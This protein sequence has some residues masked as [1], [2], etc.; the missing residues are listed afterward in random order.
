MSW[1]LFSFKPPSFQALPDTLIA[2]ERVILRP[3]KLD[4][5]PQWADIRGRNK[6]R[7]QPYE[8]T[9]AKNSLEK[10]FFK[11]RLMRQYMEWKTDHARPFL[12]FKAEDHALIGGININNICRGAAQYASLGYWIDADHEEQGY[13]RE[14]LAMI[15]RYCFEDM[16]LHRIHAACLP[17]NT[18]SHAL[19][20]GAG[21]QEEGF[22]PRYLYIN[23]AWRD[24]VLFG[25]C[26]EDYSS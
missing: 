6:D 10:E 22:A 18:G 15:I 24:H 11:K 25:L 14:A 2:G 8:P 23:G 19:L 12:I 5:W 1:P 3:P 9:W 21:F 20:R 16:K 4:D 26:C 13:M 17:D 7:L